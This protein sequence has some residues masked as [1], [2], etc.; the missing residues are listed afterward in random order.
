MSME[1]ATASPAIIS[2]DPVTMPLVGSRL[3][4]A[5]A[6]TGKTYTI[7]AL[8]V[9]LVLERRLLPEQILVVTFTEAATEELRDR[10]R[11]TLSEAAEYF[12]DSQVGTDKDYLVTL[13]EQ[14]TDLPAAA[15][16]LAQAALNMDEAAV[17]TIHGWCNRML[18]EHAFAS[19]SLFT[20]QLNTDN[21]E[22]W[23]Q[24]AQD[25]WRS[26]IAPLAANEVALYQAFIEA[27]ATPA[28]L[29]KRALKLVAHTERLPQVVP[30][31]LLQQQAEQ[32]E[33]LK[34]TFLELP[35]AKWSDD[36][37]AIIGQLRTEGKLKNANKIQAASVAKWHQQLLAWAQQLAA[38]Q[39][40]LQPSLKPE[41]GF[42]RL[43]PDGMDEVVPSG[44]PEHPFWQKF[45]DLQQAV[46]KLPELK[47]PLL[48]HAAHWLQ[49]RFAELQRQR[50][51]M[52]FDDMLTRLRRAL[53]SEQGPLLASTIKQQFPVAMI[54][55][56]QDTD[57]VQ[58]D[59]FDRVY[60]IAH[61]ADPCGV[62][63]IGDPKQ[64]I[65]SFRNADIYTYLKARRA[66]TGRHYTLAKNFRSTD[67]MVA[68]TNALFKQAES[69]PLG[70]FMFADPSSADN[71]VP[72][73]E[74]AANG[75]SRT[76]VAA[77][78]PL[79]ALQIAMYDPADKTSD[80][81]CKT[82]LAQ[83]FA[84][85]IVQL[86]NDPDSGF[87]TAD[88]AVQRVQPGDIAVL[89]N[90]ANEARLMRDALRQRQ[91][92]S[93][94][95]S[96]RDSVFAGV[97]A[98][99]LLTLLQ[100]C[101]QPRDPSL[102]RAALSTQL[103]GLSLAEL[104]DYFS[105]ELRWDQL[106]DQMIEYHHR[107]QRQGVLP[108][109][110]R[111]LHD[112]KVPARLLQ[113]VQGERQL[114]DVLHLAEL[115]QQHAAVTEGMTGVLRYLAEHIQ[116][117]QQSDSRTDSSEQQV[118]LESDSQLVQVITIHKSKGL[119]YP[120][121]FLPFISN[122]WP[123]QFR[124]Q[125][126]ASY[127]DA[128]GELCFAYD[129]QDE[130][131]IEAAERERLAED[132]R[133]LYVAA[134]RAQ[135]ATFVGIAPF[136]EFKNSALHYILGGFNGPIKKLSGLLLPGTA[137]VQQI[138]ASSSLETYQPPLQQL[139]QLAHCR[140]PAG[141]Q[142]QSWW[143]ASYS[144][145]KYGEMSLVEDDADGLNV[146]EGRYDDAPETS[147]VGLT[148][149]LFEQAPVLG[150]IHGFPKGAGPGTFLHHLLETA[151]DEGFATVAASTE[152]GEQLAEQASLVET[153]AEEADMLAHWLVNYLK[154]PF[155]VGEHQ[156]R[157]ADLTN[158]QAEP[159]FWFEARSVSA[160]SID[161]LVRKY[162]LVGHQR[163]L[164]LPAKLNG[165]LK[166][167]IDLV[168]EFDGKYYVADYK[169]NYLGA[170]AEAYT[171]TAM[172]DKI[173]ASRYDL[174]Y[175]IYTLALHKLLQARLGDAYDYDTHVGG[176]VYLFMRGYETD[177]GGAFYD[178]PPRALILELEALFMGT[179]MSTAEVTHG[180]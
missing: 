178:R 96:D 27:F 78:Q 177:H 95:L 85:T 12:R 104:D 135:Y 155:K 172:R 6:G 8:Y 160:Q 48:H 11:A 179:T 41:S 89:V 133:K 94:Y 144:A 111:L 61:T 77:Q 128:N 68:A 154:T 176:A 174:Q 161:H 127:H 131:G 140:M 119:Q 98:T 108:M 117:A 173:L 162:V 74:V 51:E 110:Q 175:V 152:L 57:P 157:L 23:L 60:D 42:V 121:V 26:F 18:R 86:L 10:I 2:L 45:A 5:S 55:E 125:Y 123:K 71:P 99:D 122:V 102:V 65:Y 112:F 132:I 105:D 13:R 81:E 32:I 62:F 29:L 158:Y 170:N 90:S 164:L 73:I 143:V 58:Y 72:F 171:Q 107:W 84:A 142:L 70:A 163:P 30:H 141:Y 83:H 37:V 91:V 109:L 52:G 166:G 20:Q 15:Q 44:V 101:A 87:K 145:L 165:M 136:K 116:L 56:F 4:E 34:H 159:E 115:L 25:Y 126:P 43:T 150:T 14:Q 168:F 88:G 64:A 66:T 49:Q 103:L 169:S 146:L 40:V 22:L 97:V 137:A 149:E 75:L 180:K 38:G 106:A 118:R 3:I 151:A 124:V 113:Q 46:A 9:R 120:L 39:L 139:P 167:F 59:I 16:L 54:D 134:T 1:Q 129:K 21:Q 93:V 33:Q 35:W 50:A 92:Q 31:Q 148:S 156:L 76:F 47:T 79:A 82:A 63:L 24:T 147:P 7:A 138:T 80:G 153:W 69:S 19:G 130:K 100:G 53:H 17:H 28:E 67:A 114:T 36:I